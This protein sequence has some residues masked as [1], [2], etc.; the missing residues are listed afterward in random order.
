M[1][2]I[3]TKAQS[4]VEQSRVNDDFQGCDLSWKLGEIALNV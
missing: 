4:W 1:Y 2:T 3:I